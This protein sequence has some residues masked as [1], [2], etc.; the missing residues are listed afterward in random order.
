M[1]I[2][3]RRLYSADFTASEQV[4]KYRKANF[5]FC[6]FELGPSANRRIHSQCQGSETLN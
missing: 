4:V 2:A 5:S 3:W 6:H 1:A